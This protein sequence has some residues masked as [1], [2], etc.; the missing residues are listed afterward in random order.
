VTLTPPRAAPSAAR[1]PDLARV[2]DLVPSCARRI[3]HLGCGRGV[4]ALLLKL[5]R[6]DR[7]VIGVVG[8][9]TL[10]RQAREHCDEVVAAADTSRLPPG[11]FDCIIASDLL[12]RAADPAL[13][14]ASALRL[15]VPGGHLIVEA[16]SAAHARALALASTSAQG[17]AAGGT[18]GSAHG[19]RGFTRRGVIELLRHSG[20]EV[21]GLRLDLEHATPDKPLPLVHQRGLRVEELE[22]SLAPRIFVNAVYAEA[23]AWIPVCSVIVRPVGATDAT[24]AALG[25]EAQRL[26]LQVVVAEGK[27]PSDLNAAV[28][29]AR[30]RYIAFLDAGTVPQPGWLTAM[31]Q[32]LQT[33][34]RAGAVGPK[35]EAGQ[36]L[37]ADGALHADAALHAA[38]LDAAVSAEYG[39]GIDAVALPYRH[40]PFPLRQ[41]PVGAV[42]GVPA[43]GVDGMVMERS[44]FI[45]MAGFDERLRVRSFDADLCLRLRAHGRPVLCCSEGVVRAAAT[46]V[47]DATAASDRRYFGDKWSPAL[48]AI[49][50]D[51]SVAE[52]PPGLQLRSRVQGRP[53]LLWSGYVFGPSGYA[54]STRGFLTALERAGVQTLAS[55]FAHGNP[56]SLD[57]VV[58]FDPFL[59][60]RAPQ[61]FVSIVSRPAIF[62]RRQAQEHIAIGRT[63]NE[64]DRI[65]N[66][67]VPRCNQMDQIWVP[68]RFNLEAF[69]RSGVDAERVFVIPETIDERMYGPSV[70]PLAVE[71]VT[72]FV[73]LSVFL[74]GPR[75]GWK[76]LL[77]AYLDEFRCEE[78]VTLLLRVSPSLRSPLREL[79]DF[80]REHTGDPARAPRVVL[81][82]GTVDGATMP[83]LYRSADAFVLPSRGE[84]WGR[85]YMEAMASGLPTIGTG[86]SGNTDFMDEHNSYLI[87]YTLVPHNDP[88]LPVHFH[89]PEQTL[90]AEPSLDHL[91]TLMRTVF[92]NRDA[93]A[94]RGALARQ[95]VLDRFRH[96]KVADIVIERLQQSG[97]EV[98]RSKAPS[99]AAE[100]QTPAAEA[101]SPA[102]EVQTPAAEARSP[103][104]QAPSISVILVA[105]GGADRAAACVRRIET[106][107]PR[108]AF[109]LVVVMCGSVALPIASAVAAA[110]RVV[111]VSETASDATAR[112]AGAGAAAGEHLVFV[113]DDVWPQPGWADALVEELRASSGTAVVG[114]RLVARDGTLL[115]AGLVY[116]PDLLPYPIHRGAEP[117]APAAGQARAVSAVA[118]TG[119]LI[120][121]KSLLAVGGFDE[122]L[123][124]THADAALCQRMRELGL[125][126]VYCPRSTLVHDERA[127]PGPRLEREAAAAF[128]ERWAPSLWCD[129]EARCEEDGSDVIAAR[130]A[131]WQMPPAG[132]VRSA[133]EPAVLWSAPVFDRSGYANEAR[134]YVLALDEAGVDVYVNAYPWRHVPSDLPGDEV[135]RI[136]EL[137]RA[138]LPSD[139]VHVIQHQAIRF[140]RHPQALANVGRTMFETDSLPQDR[141]ER[142]NAMDE[143]WVPS[144]FNAQTF[145]AAGVD[146]GR[147]VVIPEA[148]DADLYG[149]AAEPLLIPDARGFV[150]L[151]VFAWSPRKGWDVLLRAFGDEFA[152]SDDVTLV[153]AIS[154]SA[155]GMPGDPAPAVLSYLRDALGRD[156]AAT[157]RIVVL[158]LALSP[159]KMPALYAA[160]DAFVLPSRGEGWG[161][162]YMEAMACGLP[163]IGTGWSGNTE[164]MNAGN[165]YLI[166]FELVDLPEEG[167]ARPGLFRGQ[168]WAAPS[169]EHL[170]SLMRHV[171]THREEARR[172]GGRARAE[173]LERYDRRRI[174]QTMKV[175]LAALGSNPENAVSWPPRRK[176]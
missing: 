2:A 122:A 69:V 147:L 61:S 41:A 138:G 142:C 21:T 135:A 120:R 136:A 95:S 96:G 90:W 92:E 88:S 39:Q 28:R 117:A 93:A 42:S 172:I 112:N 106:N 8:D 163:T 48:E 44:R 139:F 158:P 5:R 161:R 10:V 152:A 55:P 143:V 13:A 118:G 24:M 47:D 146:A 128:L 91:R 6:P 97:I 67:W 156:P 33:N 11:S 73:F 166:D 34:P 132:R 35:R 145:A 31:I 159:K 17:G 99:P 144:R 171:Y 68:S 7:H 175:R 127:R 131:A 114:S 4:A 174:A 129:D 45:E 52:R 81:C 100:V 168:R 62:F 36:A 137:A 77:Q 108:L 130:A 169:V 26:S 46:D 25:E 124:G 50:L 176:P 111:S 56:S 141:V 3:L 151:S 66:G 160:A 115:H 79:T 173:I 87:E 76:L 51:R 162:P 165:S 54:E 65:P 153:L 74:L 119:M 29:A 14:L 22:E 19:V 30:G 101:P 113:D 58:D 134:D 170:R 155:A 133:R 20:C 154:T 86:W 72:G 103:V 84:G 89:T 37:Q 27:T 149:A 107:S 167:W 70:A 110:V 15:L 80:I 57:E 49:Q 9:A 125:E 40:E 83:R 64:T 63:M 23:A 116:G 12:E 150:F 53:A 102:A 16:P 121:R 157:A 78:D 98:A 126:I 59:V 18:A 164:F 104:A 105:R 123:E 32:A 94:R 38:A 140:W 85:P 1:D 109:E 75:K 43:V 60:E 148:I 71:N 82:P